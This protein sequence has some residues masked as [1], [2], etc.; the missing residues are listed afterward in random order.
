MDRCKILLKAWILFCNK[1]L[2][3]SIHI[4]MTKRITH[5]PMFTT[6]KLVFAFDALIITL[7]IVAIVKAIIFIA[8]LKESL[9]KEEEGEKHETH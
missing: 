2:M 8:N 3:G 7:V 4:R 6:L 9:F 1:S 5:C